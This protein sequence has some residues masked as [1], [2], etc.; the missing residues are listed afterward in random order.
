MHH[1]YAVCPNLILVCAELYPCTGDE[2][3]V[4]IK[5][6]QAGALPEG[7]ILV[8]KQ[9]VASCKI[10]TPVHREAVGGKFADCL[11]IL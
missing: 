3:A 5:A 2:N 1:P 10:K 6:T 11:D 8:S 9:R 4:S 7:S